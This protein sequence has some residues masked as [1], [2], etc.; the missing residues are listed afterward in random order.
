MN[1][2]DPNQDY[3]LALILD[4][5]TVGSERQLLPKW[6]GYEL[7]PNAWEP[8]SGLA[9]TGALKVHKSSL[10]TF[11]EAMSV[12]PIHIG[13]RSSRLVY[14]KVACIN[15]TSCET[16]YLGKGT[17]AERASFDLKKSIRQAFGA[18]GPKSSFRMERCIAVGD[19]PSALCA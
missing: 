19:L 14:A 13:Y 10:N 7:D 11:V 1:A 4:E 9:N 5:R 12:S 16:R 6:K 18:G 17:D 2:A 15:E 8:A 3:T